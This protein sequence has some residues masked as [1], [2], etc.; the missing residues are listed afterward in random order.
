M[1]YTPLLS[2]L[3]SSELISAF[4]MP[5]ITKKVASAPSCFSSLA[6]FLV[7]DYQA[8]RHADE[9]VHRFDD[10]ILDDG[11]A[12]PDRNSISSE[13]S[14][15]WMTRKMNPRRAAIPNVLVR[16]N[17]EGGN[18]FGSN[19][20]ASLAD[21]YERDLEE[22]MDYYDLE[23]MERDMYDRDLTLHDGDYMS[24]DDYHF[25]EDITMQVLLDMDLHY[26]VPANVDSRFFDDLTPRERLLHPEVFVVEGNLLRR[27]QI[28]ENVYLIELLQHD[29]E[30]Y[31]ETIL[32]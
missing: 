24:M 17:Y 22:D 18:R 25:R 29:L 21:R 28:P 8:R 9:L 31:M 30:E 20:Y 26:V 1:K 7:T 19:A 2:L 16:R 32:Y 10:V 13:A 3:F 4:V 12:P 15:E 23:M 27:K 11:F 5:Q 6:R 14:R